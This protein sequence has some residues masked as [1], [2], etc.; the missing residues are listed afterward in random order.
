[1]GLWNF[2]L[3][4]C[5]FRHEF[6]SLLFL[7]ACLPNIALQAQFSRGLRQQVM[8]SWTRDSQT[9]SKSEPLSFVSCYLRHLIIL[10]S[11]LTP[12]FR[13]F[14]LLLLSNFWVGAF[15]KDVTSGKVI[16]ALLF[17]TGFYEAQAGLELPILPSAVFTG[18]CLKLCLP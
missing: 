4:L 13:K 6:S 8:V 12:R 2:D 7:L 16:F 3:C 1:M 14:Y 17:V 5:V 9:V 11:W 10:R 15:S 18:L